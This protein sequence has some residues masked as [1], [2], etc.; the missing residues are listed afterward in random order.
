[1]RFVEGRDVDHVPTLSSTTRERLVREAA[2]HLAAIHG[3]DVPDRYGRLEADNGELVVTPAFDSW[4]A[5]FDAMAEEVVAALRGEGALTD[6]E[7]RFADLAS[8]VRGA[9]ADARAVPESPAPSLVV[10]DYRLANLMLAGDDADPLVRGVLD[11]SGLVGDPLLDVAKTE[12][13]LV[14]LPLGGT[15]EAD[16]LR[17]TFRATY[18]ERRGHDPTAL[19]DERYPC[20]RLYA[21]AY[22]LKAFDYAL[23]FT[24]ETDPDVVAERSR[25]FVADRLGEVRNEE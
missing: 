12:E 16:T 15:D 1:M 18:G 23:G 21:R 17:E 22:R 6:P 24:R 3:L 13:A 19:F 9:L 4:R 20:Y 7:P 25:A 11:T 5:Q 14:D 10:R 8:E 2:T